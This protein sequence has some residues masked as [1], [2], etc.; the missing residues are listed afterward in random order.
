MTDPRAVAAGVGGVVGGVSAYLKSK[1]HQRFAAALDDHAV[2][3]GA[4]TPETKHWRDHERGSSALKSGLLGAAA[5]TAVGAGGAHLVRENAPTLARAAQSMVSKAVEEP[6]RRAGEHAVR[7]AA[8]ETRR[9]AQTLGARLRNI[10]TKKGSGMPAGK[11]VVSEI[12]RELG[13][14][15]SSF[16]GHAID[17]GLIGAVS[18]AAGAPTDEKLRTAGKGAVRGAL[19]GDLSVTSRAVNLRQLSAVRWLVV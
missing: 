6:A 18:G 2:A 13:A 8:A 12:A 11:K 17:G 7:G 14:H 15:S 3:T 19:L 4:M 9:G 1:D 10:F 5:G 16:V